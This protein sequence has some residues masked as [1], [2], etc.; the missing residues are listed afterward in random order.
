MEG[1]N[2]TPMLGPENDDSPPETALEARKRPLVWVPQT[3]R[4]QAK[5]QRLQLCRWLT[6]CGVAALPYSRAR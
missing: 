2:V 3:T 5:A 6:T 4:L 1:L